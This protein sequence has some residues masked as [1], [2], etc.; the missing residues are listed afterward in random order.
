MNNKPNIKHIISN[1]NKL[2]T[3]VC[4]TNFTISVKKN[5]LTDSRQDS[6]HF[7]TAASTTNMRWKLA[8]HIVKNMFCSF[9]WEFPKIGPW[10][11]VRICWDGTIM[12]NNAQYPEKDL[13]MLFSKSMWKLPDALPKNHLRIGFRL[14]RGRRS[15]ET[16]ALIKRSSLV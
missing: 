8:A 12:I 7:Q 14:D 15:S 9:C 3:T 11:K 10:S 2:K 4:F 16:W 1:Y 6:K 5:T 13:L